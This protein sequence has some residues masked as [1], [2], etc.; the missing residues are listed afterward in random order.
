[1]G[2]NSPEFNNTSLYTLLA[3][4]FPIIRFSSDFRFE[5]IY[6]NT[7]RW[8]DLE[9]RDRKSLPYHFYSRLFHYF[10]N[11][12]RHLQVPL[13]TSSD[14]INTALE[15]CIIM[16]FF[17][18]HPWILYQ[19]EINDFWILKLLIRR[20]FSCFGSFDPLVVLIFNYP[21]PCYSKLIFQTLDFYRQSFLNFLPTINFSTRI[22]G[23]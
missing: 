3:I 5:R 18:Y 6:G 14:T 13:L 10:L 11:F 20:D 9:A 23:H 8:A 16:L 22:P 7:P 2:I 21:I 19:T 1:M 4:Q 12:S 15:E 17:N